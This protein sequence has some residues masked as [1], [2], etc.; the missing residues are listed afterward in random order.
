MRITV[1]NI[2]YPLTPVSPHAVGGAE[3]VLSHL[4]AA[5]TRAGHRSIVV[6]CGRSVT[7]GTLAAMP[8]VSRALTNDGRRWVRERHRTVIAQAVNRW[9][10]DVVHIHGIDFYTYLPPPDVPVLV[11]LHLLLAW[12]PSG[13]FHPQRPQTYLPCVSAG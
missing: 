1:L 10:V 9:P 5:L 11:T 2:A 8:A 4:D 3:Q 6:A 13:V 12:Y 7:A